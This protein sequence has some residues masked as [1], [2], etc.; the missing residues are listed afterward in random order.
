MKG[1]RILCLSFWAHKKTLL[2][3]KFK[4]KAD[5]VK[6]S[7]AFEIKISNDRVSSRP[8]CIDDPIVEAKGVFAQLEPHEMSDAE[9]KRFGHLNNESSKLEDAD[10][11]KVQKIPTL[12]DKIRRWF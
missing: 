3:V 10:K 2:I 7:Q 6:P 4:F 8:D 9:R 11:P 12:W 1:R 5:V